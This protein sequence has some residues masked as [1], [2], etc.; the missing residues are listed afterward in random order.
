MWL[1]DD[2]LQKNLLKALNRFEKQG[3]EGKSIFF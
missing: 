3:E 2:K 1:G